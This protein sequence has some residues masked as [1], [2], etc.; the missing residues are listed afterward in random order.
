MPAGHFALACYFEFI[1]NRQHVKKYRRWITQLLTYILVWLSR[2]DLFMEREKHL[3]SKTVHAET[4]SKSEKWISPSHP[5]VTLC[6]IC[7]NVPET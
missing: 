7:G 4:S 5:S 1:Y 3:K 6:A 2:A